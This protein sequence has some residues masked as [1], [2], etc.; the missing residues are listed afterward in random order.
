[1]HIIIIIIFNNIKYLF[2]AFSIKN[3]QVHIIIIIII[4][5]I[6]IVHYRHYN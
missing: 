5:I 6:I 1:M 3:I 2:Y 4:N